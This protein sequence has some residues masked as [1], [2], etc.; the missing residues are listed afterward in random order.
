MPR[1]TFADPKTDFAFKRIF[2]S[3]EHKDVLAVPR[4]AVVTDEN[5]DSVVAL[6]EGDQAT[7]KTVTAGFEENGQIEITA[8]GLKEG[9]T[10]A[11]AGAFGLPQ[12]TK[13]KVLD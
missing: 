8:D 3:E 5:G 9:D 4:E 13:V 7:R 10:V 11:T 2:G 1:P 6:I 12:A